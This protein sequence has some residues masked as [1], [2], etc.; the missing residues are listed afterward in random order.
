MHIMLQTEQED[1][2][3]N[4]GNKGNMQRR[5]RVYLT[6]VLT[7]PKHA[8]SA[9]H[10]MPTTATTLPAVKSYWGTPI[11]H[12]PS[13][14]TAAERTGL[15]EAIR[16]LRTVTPS[17]LKSNFG[18]WQSD[19]HLCER[20]SPLG[21]TMA[22]TLRRYVYD[23]L[24][25]VLQE[26]LQASDCTTATDGRRADGQIGRGAKDIHIYADTRAQ[27]TT[28]CT[29]ADDLRAHFDVEVHE[30]WAGV[31]RAGQGN[32]AHVH[33]KADMSGVLYVAAPEHAGRLVF[34]DPRGLLAEV[35]GA[36]LRNRT[37]Q[38]AEGHTPST[39]DD[40]L[41][42]ADAPDGVDVEVAVQPRAGDVVVFPSWLEHRVDAHMMDGA[43]H[44]HRNSDV[45]DGRDAER[46]VVAFNARVTYKLPNTAQFQVHIPQ[47]HQD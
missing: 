1:G 45:G 11:A 14:V 15:W 29:A 5:P 30:C 41:D 28:H 3:D 36:P 21:D 40:A 27:K 6:L 35:W 19:V 31:A 7:A 34:S 47:R 38:R 4:T 33:P 25:S 16:R 26:S 43:T 37:W 22:A 42:T 2:G 18:G 46:V 10:E 20:A 39:R 13:V 24:V 44:G 23:T 12:V 32:Y 8:V 17:V 9:P